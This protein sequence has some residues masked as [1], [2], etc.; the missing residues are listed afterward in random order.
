MMRYTHFLWDWNGTLADDRACAQAAVNDI[1][2]E[3]SRPPITTEQYY[4]YLDTP[5][6]RFYEHLFD[7]EQEDY[8]A[9]LAEY[10]RYY[11]Q[12]MQTEGHLRVGVRDLLEKAAAR[13][14]CQWVVTASPQTDVERYLEHFGIRR[15]FAGVYG[16]DN[17]LSES[18]VERIRHEAERQGLEPHRVLVIGDTLH[19]RELAEALRADCALL[20]EGHQAE[21]LLRS[22]HTG[23]YTSAAELQKELAL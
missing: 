9:L 13:G 10:N 12:H 4:A 22:A 7:L 16:A 2:R 3:R 8:P 17:T 6:R 11:H 1:L 20:C 19:D 14:I 23:V 5:I 21:E 15:F 18:K